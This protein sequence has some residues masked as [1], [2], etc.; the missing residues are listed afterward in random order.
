METGTIDAKTLGEKAEMIDSMEED[1]KFMILWGY[2]WIHVE[3]SEINPQI[4]DLRKLKVSKLSSGT[5][6]LEK[7]DD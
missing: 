1:D 2:Q 6:S 4:S 7:I 5:V 3:Q